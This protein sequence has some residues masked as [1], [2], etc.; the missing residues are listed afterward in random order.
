M[1]TAELRQH[2]NQQFP[3]GHWPKTFLVDASTYGHVCDTILR[4]IALDRQD[5]ETFYSANIILGP[6]HGLMF[7]NVELILSPSSKAL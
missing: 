6:H 7:K 2:F 3:R 1:T 4:D 5:F